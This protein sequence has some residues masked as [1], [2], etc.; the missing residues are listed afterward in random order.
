MLGFTTGFG[1][2]IDQGNAQV[3][4]RSTM[5]QDSQGTSVV[6]RCKEAQSRNLCVSEEKVNSDLTEVE[7]APHVDML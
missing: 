2:P 3:K 7:V 6:R 1:V 5:I 4:P